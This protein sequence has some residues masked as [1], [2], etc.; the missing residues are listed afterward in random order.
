M[1]T[2]LQILTDG[3]YELAPSVI[4][5]L[6]TLV[7]LPGTR[8]YFRPG[9]DLEVA[10]SN[11]TEAREDLDSLQSTAQVASIMLRSWPGLFYLSLYQHRSIK[12]L[13]LAL[14][15]NSIEVQEKIL[16]MLCNLLDIKGKEGKAGIT[17]STQRFKPPFTSHA[18]S[19]INLYD[20]YLA[21]LVLILVECGLVEAIVHV[22]EN[23]TELSRKATLLMGHLTQIAAHHL[24][25]EYGV[26]I[27]ALPDLFRAIFTRPFQGSSSATGGKGERGQG[28]EKASQALSTIDNYEREQARIQTLHSL[29]TPIRSTLVVTMN[30]R[31]VSQ[32][33]EA[34]FRSL[35]LEANVLNTKEYTKWNIDALI[36]TFEALQNHSKRLEE[37]IRVSK[38][39]KRA[40][41]FFH[42]FSLQYST[43]ANTNK[44]QKYTK[45]GCILLS[46]L[47]THGEGIRLLAD[48]KLLKEIRESLSTDLMTSQ[49]TKETLTVGYF[50]MLG[51][52]T[53][54]EEGRQLMHK[55]KLYS[56]LYRAIEEHGSEDV[57]KAILQHFDFASPGHCRLLLS[58][59]LT[60]APPDIRIYATQMVT[61][62]IRLDTSRWLIS[63]LVNQLYDIEASIRELASTLLLQLCSSSTKAL[64]IIVSL[65]PMLEETSHSLLLKFISTPVG[66]RYLLQGGYVDREMEEWFNKRNYLYT[67][68]LEVLL[69]RGFSIDRNQ[70]DQH[71]HWDGCIPP[72]FYGE[73]AKTSDGCAV[74][75]QKGHF[76]EFAHFIRTHAMEE[77]D[78]EII[79]KVKSTLWAVGNIGATEGGLSL[80]EGE[81]F[82]KQIVKVAQESPVFSLRGTC[83]FVLG[84]ISTTQQGAELVEDYGWLT[85]A[86]HDDSSTAA[87][88]CVPSPAFLHV[89]VWKPTIPFVSVAIDEPES[90]IERIIMLNISNLG[91]SILANK[92]SRTLGKIKSKHRRL[93]MKKGIELFARSLFISDYHCLR[94]AVRRYIWELFE[95]KLDQTCVDHI[96]EA[97]KRFLSGKKPIRK[98]S[99]SAS[100]SAS[101]LE[102]RRQGDEVL[103][104]EGEEGNV[105]DEEGGDYGDDDDDDDDEEDEDDFGEGDEEEQS[106]MSSHYRPLNQIYQ[107]SSS[108]LGEVHHKERG[109][110]TTH[111]QHGPNLTPKRKLVGGFTLIESSLVEV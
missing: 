106:T 89:P 72:H 55:A 74:L 73:L 29:S 66:L 56:A 58:K 52:L 26:R 35:L 84:L 7:D 17:A 14:R 20:H 92:A 59:I 101:D 13:V 85:S 42:P 108:K 81:D 2:V 82:I 3:P 63:L 43:I 44:S 21:L 75:K 102:L 54:E 5:L 9:F 19:K 38:L 23:R 96:L 27:H 91:N 24:P 76:T 64:E 65:R 97:R 34:T 86:N 40:L 32:V 60:T 22:L 107:D 48:D 80:L 37:T 71:L 6:L 10:L 105:M 36:Q 93:F 39:F 46:S 8:K 53:R 110:S 12:S 62:M 67:V 16:D 95:I 83:Y 103:G 45:L 18:T 88:Y 51:V 47:L 69:A 31:A 15:V 98:D 99:L 4:T 28:Q 41:A 61:D 11:L 25:S 77:E 57:I 68:Q 79:N 70:D 104:T 30:T 94:Q 109:M 49:R 100:A 50:E 90:I 33:D 87:S 1:S 78:V 111:R